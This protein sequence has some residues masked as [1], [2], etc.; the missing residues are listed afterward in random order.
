[1]TTSIF[2]RLASQGTAASKVRE[3]EEK[4][5]RKKQEARRAANTSASSPRRNSAKLQHL[6]SPQDATTPK[7]SSKHKQEA[8]F[9]RLAK[10]ETASS[11]AH[12]TT[13][14]AKKGAIS[15]KK[16]T[17]LPKKKKPTPPPS[18]LQRIEDKKKSE[19][20]SSSSATPPEMKLHIRSIEEKNAT[21]P[22]KKLDMSEKE[23]KRQIHLYHSNKISAH[24]LAFDI[25]TALFDQKFVS[26]RDIHSHWDIGTATLEALDP[27]TTKG[28]HTIECYA[29]EKSAVHHKDIN[30]FAKLKCTIKLSKE[31][32]Y[33]DE[34]S[35][36]TSV[37]VSE[38]GLEAKKKK[39][40]EEAAVARKSKEDEAAAVAE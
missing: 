1:M 30:K 33:V 39:A 11:H 19:K 9:N 3:A 40:E 21:K 38:D 25:I 4:E 16:T 20:S 31:N 32:V 22:Y 35:Y 2:D 24:A 15:P 36:V 8:F 5:T 37:E 17:V 13:I 27:I 10:A 7:K 34:Y 28:G 6:K 26:N 12:H 23:I 14:E 29:A 18:L